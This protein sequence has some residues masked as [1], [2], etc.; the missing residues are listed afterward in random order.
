MNIY[1]VVDTN[2]LI[3]ALLSKND[4]SAT[5]KV[6]AAMLQGRFTPL[7]HEAILDEY[8]EVLRREK[9][10]FR[11]DSIQKLLLAVRTYGKYTIPCSI[12][13]DE[14]PTDA[15]DTIFWQI[16]M[17][18]RDNGAYLITG[19]GK[20]FPKREFVVTPAQMVSLFGW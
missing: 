9:F 2:V 4:D 10:H 7:W 20:H 13:E 6:L 11:E 15:D 5:V 3:A 19:N 12:V 17:T 8:N 1:A 14:Q 16:A 18:E